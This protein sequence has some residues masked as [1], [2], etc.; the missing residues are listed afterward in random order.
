MGV[1][2]SLWDSDFISLNKYSEVELLDFMV[3]L[4]LI[5]WAT[6]VLFSIE[7]APIYIPTNSTQKLSFLHSL[8]NTCLLFIDN[9]HSNRY[10]V[11][12]HCGFGLHFSDQIF[13][14]FFHTIW[15]AAQISPREFWSHHP[16]YSSLSVTLYWPVLYILWTPINNWNYLVHLFVYLLTVRLLPTKIKASREQKSYLCH[17]LVIFGDKKTAGVQ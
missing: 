15:T 14:M 12:S 16:I 9:S 7:V 2:T 4:F 5:F 11:I 17:S 10:E 13:L 1:Q 3:V 6:S 8:A